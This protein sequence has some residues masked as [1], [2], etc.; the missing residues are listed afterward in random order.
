MIYSG[1]AN[2]FDPMKLFLSLLCTGSVFFCTAQKKADPVV[3]ANSIKSENLE[4]LLYQIAGPA[5]KAGKPLL[6]VSAKRQLYIEDYFK[7][8]GLKP[9]NKDSFQLAYPVYQDSLISSGINVNGD[10]I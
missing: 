4:K 7:K 3:F 2:I 6:P 5:L 1:G 10:T 9:G 8:L